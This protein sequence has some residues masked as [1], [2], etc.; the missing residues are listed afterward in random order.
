MPLDV[1]WVHRVPC[2]FFIEVLMVIGLSCGIA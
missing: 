2:V 1:V